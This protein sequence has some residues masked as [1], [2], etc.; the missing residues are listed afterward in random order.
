MEKRDTRSGALNAR[1]ALAYSTML[2]ESDAILAAASRLNGSMTEAVELI[3]N[4]SG[5]VVVSGVGKSGLVGQKIVA[6]LCSTG[7]P[8]VFLHPTEAL[9]GDLGVYEPGDPTILISKSGGTAELVR[10][11]PLLRQFESPLIGILGST[12]GELAAQVDVLLDGSVDSE[13]DPCNI[14]PTNSAVVAMSLGDALASALMQAKNFTLDDFAKFHAGGQLGRNLLLTVQDAF[15]RR[16]AAASVQPTDTVKEVVVAMT[17]HPLGAACVVTK[18]GKLQGIITD[19]DLRRALQTHDDIR[20]LRAAEIMTPSPIAVRLHTR[21][22]DALA[23]MENRP[24]Q[25]SVLPVVDEGN[26]W[27]GLIRIHDIYRPSAAGN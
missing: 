23:L 10:L 1:L 14:A 25:I 13:A 15:H 20:A 11:V 5:K 4:H 6:T 21:L 22:K 24:S 16:D 3:L 8:A 27:L 7:T 26:H 12:E 19:G 18:D 2:A 9:H 17:R